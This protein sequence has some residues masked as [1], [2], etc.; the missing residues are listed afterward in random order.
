MN[1][2]GSDD[3]DAGGRHG[4]Q[5]FMCQLSLAASAV[6]APCRLL[7]LRVN[8]RCELYAVSRFSHPLSLSLSLALSLSLSRI[9]H[10]PRSYE[11]W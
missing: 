1:G 5:R 2:G 9:P 10:C 11:Q 7:A 4:E 3:E 8:L 6:G